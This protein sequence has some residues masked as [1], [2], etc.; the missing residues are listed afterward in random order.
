[1]HRSYDVPSFTF[2]SQ[3]LKLAKASGLVSNFQLSKTFRASPEAVVTAADQ[4]GLEVCAL[5]A[6]TAYLS[7]VKY[8]GGY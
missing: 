8:I 2:W 5:R 1:M 4:D 7:V 6:I 3:I